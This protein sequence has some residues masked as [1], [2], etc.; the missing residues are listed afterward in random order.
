MLRDA[1]E[2]FW[3]RGSGTAPFECGVVF[4]EK[5]PLARCFHLT[6]LCF[7]AGDIFNVAKRTAWT[8]KESGAI[9]GRGG[10][11]SGYAR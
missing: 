11:G 8:T 9:R 5:L 10:S 7:A 3:A 4:S 1:K 2:G 6:S